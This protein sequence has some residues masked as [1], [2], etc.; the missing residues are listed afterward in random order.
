MS[1]NNIRYS[2]YTLTSDII[3]EFSCCFFQIGQFYSCIAII[4]FECQ[5][6]KN[7]Y[8]SSFRI[9]SRKFFSYIPFFQNHSSI[10]VQGLTKIWLCCSFSFQH[11][12]QVHT[13]ELKHKKYTVF[14]KCLFRP[15]ILQFFLHFISWWYKIR[16]YYHQYQR[17]MSGNILGKNKK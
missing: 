17:P 8:Q 12:M 9:S 13:T 16:L 7:V 14:K 4:V 6:P 11:N 15:T 3:L 2:E 1:K 5:R 10:R